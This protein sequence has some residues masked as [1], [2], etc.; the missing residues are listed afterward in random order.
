MTVNQKLIQDLTRPDNLRLLG[1]GFFDFPI[2]FNPQKKEIP[3]PLFLDEI[4]D[5]FSAWLKKENLQS[6]LI[7]KVI[8]C[9]ERVAGPMAIGR[10]FK[11]IQTDGQEKTVSLEDADIQNL[12]SE[13]KSK[14]CAANRHGHSEMDIT[15][16]V[17]TY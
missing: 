6:S 1:L 7:M 12:P 4:R 5:A 2:G 14:A 9:F 13:I 8:L 10:K 17:L 3:I 11:I 15:S 16:Q